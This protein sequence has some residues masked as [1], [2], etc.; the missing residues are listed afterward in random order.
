MTVVYKINTVHIELLIIQWCHK[1]I[2]TA[3]PFKK[4]KLIWVKV[5][6]NSSYP[7]VKIIP[8]IESRE[9]KKILK[10]I[11]AELLTSGFTRDWNYQN[12]NEKR[13]YFWSH[14]LSKYFTKLL[15]YMDKNKNSSIWPPNTAP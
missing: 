2:F 3:Y 5:T 13:W 7:E 11:V 1:Q 8:D 15:T 14:D 12:T 6:D 9:V 4:C 10:N